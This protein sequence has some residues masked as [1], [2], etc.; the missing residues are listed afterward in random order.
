MALELLL[1]VHSNVVNLARTAIPTG[2]MA[3]VD[4]I[5]PEDNDGNSQSQG[6]AA[7]KRAAIEAAALGFGRGVGHW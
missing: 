3:A 4:F 6:N 2:T 5:D 1:Q 7:S